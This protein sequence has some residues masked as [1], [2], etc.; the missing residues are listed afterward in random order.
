MRGR[1]ICQPSLRILTER[2][3]DMGNSPIH[4]P[5]CVNCPHYGCH[6]G[7]AAQKVKGAFLRVGSR[8]CSGGKRIRVFKSS[9]PKVYVPSWCPRQKSPAELRVY[10]YKDTDSWYLRQLLEQDGIRSAPSGYKYAVRY[11]GS[12][13]LTARDFYEQIQRQPIADILG[14]KVLF[15]EVVEIDDGLVPYYFHVHECGAD[16]FTYFDRDFVWVRKDAAWAGGGAHGALQG[17]TGDFTIYKLLQGFGL[18]I[19]HHLHMSK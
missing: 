3:V 7:P 11:E 1:L 8:Y 14:L 15:G 18:K 2:S 6:S 4:K 16:V 5:R 13:A 17:R 10:C 12:T 19:L 9:D